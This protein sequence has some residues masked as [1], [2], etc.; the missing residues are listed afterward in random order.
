MGRFQPRDD[1]KGV[2]VG[3]GPSHS[4]SL[5]FFEEALPL[6]VG[7]DQVGRLLVDGEVEDGAD[8]GVFDLSEDQSLPEEPFPPPSVLDMVLGEALDGD[9][10]LELRVQGEPYHTHSP[11]PQGVENLVPLSQNDSRGE[12]GEGRARTWLAQG[13]QGFP[14]EGAEVGLRRVEGSTGGAGNGFGSY[15]RAHANHCTPLPPPRQERWWATF[16]LTRLGDD[17]TFWFSGGK[18][19]RKES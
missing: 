10:L 11:T 7:H 15:V 2:A 12:G 9:S 16:L 1:L 6:D 13:L 17:A 3:L 19:G 5:H 8:V 18:H 14:A 4:P